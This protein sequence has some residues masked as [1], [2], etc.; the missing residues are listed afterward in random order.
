MRER[1]ETD[2]KFLIYVLFIGSDSSDIISPARP[3][4]PATTNNLFSPLSV[5][6]GRSPVHK[7]LF[8]NITIDSSL[9]YVMNS[10][11]PVAN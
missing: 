11:Y 1:G 6:Q 5:L 2:Y 4:S 9:N 10:F 7:K 3:G 8:G